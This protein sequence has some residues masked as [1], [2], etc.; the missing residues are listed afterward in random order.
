M[1]LEAVRSALILTWILSIQST[2][3]FQ[4]TSNSPIGRGHAHLGNG[5]LNLRQSP[6]VPS[7]EM[8]R[9]IRLEAFWGKEEDSEEEKEETE[10]APSEDTVAS[11]TT[12]STTEEPSEA[13]ESAPVS[14]EKSLLAL[15]NEIGNNFR[16]M[17]LKSTEKGSQ[18]ED[19]YKKI[20]HAAKAC[21]YYS[22]FILYRAYRGFF[23]LLPATFKQVY[24]KME[25]A[26]NA[27]NLSLDDIGFDENGK[28][29]ATT[30]S[31]WRTKV[32][33]SILTSVIT[34]SY[35]VGGV[36]KMASK[37]VRTIAKTSDVP[38]SFGAAA[39]EVM[40][41]EGRISRVGKVN[42]DSA[43]SSGLTP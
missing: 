7:H 27:G 20:L 26:M 28:D 14:T 39:D 4:L 19:Q 12:S 43:E 42:G 21:V 34:V 40:N 29:A 2:L 35:I 1:I 22:L 37:F 30:T 33:V 11:T 32:T 3:G 24:G 5:V 18:S 41:I 9:N 13:T 10:T 8:S 6:I 36:L 23:V 15:V 25:A 17:A 31:K 16:M 38:K